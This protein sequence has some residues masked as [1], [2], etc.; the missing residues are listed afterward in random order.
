MDNTISRAPRPISA[1]RFQPGEV[2]GYPRLTCFP[3]Q[4]VIINGDNEG[5]TE[6]VDVIQ[7]EDVRIKKDTP[8]LT[9]PQKV[10]RNSTFDVDI[11][12]LYVILCLL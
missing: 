4:G 8:I 9:N 6:F 12:L 10:L 5:V 1:A 3:F 11:M 7:R 2:D